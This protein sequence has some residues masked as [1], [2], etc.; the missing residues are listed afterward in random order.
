MKRTPI[1]FFLLT[2]ASFS[3]SETNDTDSVK[4]KKERPWL[5]AP[6]IVSNPSFGSGGGVMGMY[7]FNT[8]KGSTNNPASSVSALGLYS[9]TDSYF[10]GL[11]AKTYWKQDTWRV[12]AGT[13][14]PRI[15]NDF[16]LTGL[17]NVK[18]TTTAN[19]LIFQVDRRVYG[20]WFLGMKGQFM[21]IR[22]SD[23]NAAALTYFALADVE[24]N[25]SGQLGGV[26]SHD[27]RNDQRY[28]SAGHQS[29][30]SWTDVPESWGSTTSYYITEGF[31][32]QYMS[33]V[34]KQVLALR[35]YG[36]FTPSET[37]YSGL[38]TLGRF[39]D[40]RGY[41]AGKYVAENLIALQAEYRVRFTEKIGGVVFA[42]A[43]ELYDGSFKNTTSDTFYPSGGLGLRYMLN[44]ENKMNFRLD[45]AWGTG[46]ESGFYMSVGEAF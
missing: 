16:D 35:A 22:Y 18:F 30:L 36:R 45:Y 46:D 34:E 44:V 8:E 5:A 13:A 37:P 12:T 11:F 1:I 14:N 10:L 20:D 26:V 27:S 38:S 23:P 42:G 33:F 24:D 40:L 2:F 43:S 3:Y 7:F 21:D 29:E 6:M 28:P 25:T 39:G 17:G 15:N 19:I 31:Y 32:N 41:T 9:D 4:T